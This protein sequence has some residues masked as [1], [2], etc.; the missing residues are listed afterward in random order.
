MF[1]RKAYMKI[2]N[3][4]PEPKAA[5]KARFVQ[6]A[7]ENPDL[8]RGY[9]NSYYDRVKEAAF[10]ILGD[11]CFSCKETEPEFLSIDHVNNDGH[12][13]PLHHKQIYAKIARGGTE[14]FRLLCRNC[15]S[16]R[17]VKAARESVSKSSLQPGP[18]CEKCGTGTVLDANGWKR[19]QKCVRNRLYFM[20]VKAFAV[21]GGKCSC[22]PESDPDRL[23]ID[24]VRE[25]G[26]KNRSKP[27][28]VY[29]SVVRGNADMSRY[30]VLCF[31]C[32]HSKHVG[33][34]CVHQRRKT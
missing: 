21:F 22:C 18:D 5:L 27:A 25:D 26:G 12:A 4:L 29:A 7:V 13:E 30:Q 10:Q 3:Q 33:G 34:T 23:N 20:K 19:C 17:A 15:N 11:E 28:A 2:Y 1:D 24:H 9:W 32:N 14:G 16:G 6:F 8:M 31:N